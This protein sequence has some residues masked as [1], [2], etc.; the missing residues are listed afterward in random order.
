MGQTEHERT[1]LQG[2]RR[3]AEVIRH[4]AW[5]ERYPWLVQ[6]VTT[7]TRDLRLSSAG[8][9]GPRPAALAVWR[10]VWRAEGADRGV[11]TRQ[12]HGTRVS[13]H[14]RPAGPGVTGSTRE[15]EEADGHLTDQ[16][17]LLLAVTVADCVP[18][19]VVD[20]RARAVGVVHAG[21][22][23]AAAGIVEHALNQMRDH[24]GSD[25]TDLHVHLGPSICGACYEVGPEV[26]RAL[27]R[28]AP[29][30]P[31]PVDLRRSLA[32]RCAAAGVPVAHVT[33]SARCTRESPQL[34]S[35]RGGDSGRQVAFIGMRS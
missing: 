25:P 6:G 7:R 33:R 2:G 23:G 24:F 31:A 20:P 17:D 29:P 22:R 35:H 4:A 12:V 28:P 15:A 18:V 27:G 8:G 13:V 21:W 3:D 5:A 26:H 10:E 14:E 19:F 16:P 9:G 30:G 11:L 1:E 34:F 32:D